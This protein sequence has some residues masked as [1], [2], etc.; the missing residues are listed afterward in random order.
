MVNHVPYI[1]GT[2]DDAS[3]APY[4][5]TLQLPVFGSDLTSRLLSSS[6]G[7]SQLPCGCRP[8]ER[9]RR[10]ATVHGEPFLLLPVSPAA[11]DIYCT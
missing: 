7:V 4:L 10:R 2:E 6:L 9:G 1:L 5:E 11:H 8:P 3:S